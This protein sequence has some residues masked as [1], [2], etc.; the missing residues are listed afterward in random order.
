LPNQRRYIASVGA[1]YSVNYSQSGQQKWSCSSL[2]LPN[3]PEQSISHHWRH[4]IHTTT[5]R[6]WCQYSAGVVLF[7]WC[8]QDHSCSAVGGTSPPSLIDLQTWLNLVKH[9]E[10]PWS[11]FGRCRGNSTSN[12]W[13]NLDYIFCNNLGNRRRRS[14]RCWLKWSFDSWSSSRSI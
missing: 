14:N 13:I 2:L 7:G 3:I 11:S 1:C 9:G 10:C 5:I 4:S 6:W 8:R 12:N